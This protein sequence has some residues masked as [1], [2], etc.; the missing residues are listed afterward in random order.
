MKVFITKKK[1][2]NEFAKELAYLQIRADWWYYASRAEE[3]DK[4]NMSTP[5]HMFQF[6]HHE[7]S[8]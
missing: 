7:S 1:L 3:K 5:L 8:I 6:R 2:V 4:Q